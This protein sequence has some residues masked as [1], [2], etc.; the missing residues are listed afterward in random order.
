MKIIELMQP[1]SNNQ[2]PVQKVQVVSS[3]IAYAFKQPLESVFAV[4]VGGALLPCIGDYDAIL[5]TLTGEGFTL[6]NTPED[7]RAVVN[8]AQVLFFVNPDLGIYNLMFAGKSGMAVKS[9]RADIET[10][11]L[12]TSS[13]IIS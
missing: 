3:Q 6:F 12:K 13:V 10:M 2:A 11:L 5:E 1:P 8:P 9:T 4:N 7:G